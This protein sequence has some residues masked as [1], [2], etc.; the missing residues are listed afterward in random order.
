MIAVDYSTNPM[1]EDSVYWVPAVKVIARYG[2]PIA[3]SVRAI[4]KP[5]VTGSKIATEKLT[6]KIDAIYF[7]CRV[8]KVCPGE[9]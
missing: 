7:P 5:H 1:R 3:T 9:P 2:M 4:S 6:A 8:S